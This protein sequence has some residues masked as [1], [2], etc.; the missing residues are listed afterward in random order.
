MVLKESQN[1]DQAV[2]RSGSE[3]AS[4]PA[5]TFVTYDFAGETRVPKMA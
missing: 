1:Y 5:E 4:G 3:A 2:Q